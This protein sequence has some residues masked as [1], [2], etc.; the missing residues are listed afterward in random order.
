MYRHALPPGYVLK[1]QISEL[2]EEEA[3]KPDVSE[4]IEAERQKV[5]AITPITEEVW[6]STR[7]QCV[8]SLSATIQVFKEWHRKRIQAKE[9]KRQKEDAERIKKGVLNGRE[10]FLQ[11]G[12][13]LMSVHSWSICMSPLGFVA[14]DDASASDA[15]SREVDVEEEIKRMEEETKQRAEETKRRAEQSMTHMQRLSVTL[16]HT[17]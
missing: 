6:F 3:Q 1:S 14:T 4:A 7:Q 2:L 17:F 5:E 9:E 11:S 15:Y 8:S 16:V 10:I 12:H 13:D